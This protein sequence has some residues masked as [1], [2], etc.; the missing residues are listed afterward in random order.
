MQHCEM[1]SVVLENGR[2]FLICKVDVIIVQTENQGEA[3]VAY[4]PGVRTLIAAFS[5]V[6][7]SETINKLDRDVNSTR[8]IFLRVL[9]T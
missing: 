7:S 8:G 9:A 3:I 2:W 5:R 6:G 4:D 1:A